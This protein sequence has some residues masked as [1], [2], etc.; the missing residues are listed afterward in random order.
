MKIAID[1]DDV[2][3]DSFEF[4]IPFLNDKYNLNLTLEDFHSWDVK[5]VLREHHL[6]EEEVS[7][8]FL[9]F[10]DKNVLE[11]TLDKNA[12]KILKRLKH[13]GNELFILT[14]RDPKTFEGTIKWLGNY[15]GLDFFGKVIFSKSLGLSKS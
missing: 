8:I 14:G 6:M 1:V 5:K 13:E 3:C 2:L 4:F 7:D 10:L 9:H 11:F 12:I 15:F